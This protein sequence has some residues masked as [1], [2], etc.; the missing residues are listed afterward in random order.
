MGWCDFPAPAERIPVTVRSP[1]A[2]TLLEVEPI[3]MLQVEGERELPEVSRRDLDLLIAEEDEAI[4]LE[5]RRLERPPPM[6]ELKE[7][8]RAPEVEIAAPLPSP[9]ALAEVERAAE[10]LLAP[11]E[12]KPAVWEPGALPGEYLLCPGPSWGS[13]H[14]GCR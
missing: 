3:R 14:S 1:E 7:E 10:L 11:E 6:E 8:P 2:I 9:I 5:E 12:L 13:L 4:L